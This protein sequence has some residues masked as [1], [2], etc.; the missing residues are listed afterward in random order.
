M[1]SKKFTSSD[2]LRDYLDLLDNK[3]I[4][5]LTFPLDASVIPVN[6]RLR[7]SELLLWY[8]G[9]ALVE[10]ADQSAEFFLNELSF[11]TFSIRYSSKN[12]HYLDRLFEGDKILETVS[13]RK[14][15]SDLGK[16]YNQFQ[17]DCRD[18]FGD[19]FHQFQNKMKMLDALCDVLFTNYSLKEIAYRNN[20]FN[21]NSMYILFRKKYE[22]PIDSIPR[23]LTE[24]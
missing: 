16:N 18:H 13:P 17:T 1:V 7:Q 4:S 15:A 24:I 2:F 10:D 23:L 11:N 12:L 22:F 9:I 8:S 19:T 21:Y 6:L 20:F 3:L 14:L 5:L